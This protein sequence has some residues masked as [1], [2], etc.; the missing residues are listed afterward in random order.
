MTTDGLPTGSE[1]DA[2]ILKILDLV[3]MAVLYAERDEQCDPEN[4]DL[5]GFIPE[6]LA[7]LSG[8]REP[9]DVVSYRCGRHADGG[10]VMVCQVCSAPATHALSA[11]PPGAVDDGDLPSAEDVRGILCTEPDEPAVTITPHNNE[12]Q[13]IVGDFFGPLPPVEPS[14][15]QEMRAAVGSEWA[16]NQ[17]TSTGSEPTGKDVEAREI[18]ERAVANL[19]DSDLDEETDAAQEFL[20]GTP[21][22][23]LWMLTTERL[24]RV[25]EV[26]VSDALF[27]R[28]RPVEPEPV[29]WRWRSSWDDSEPGWHYH[30]DA[31]PPRLIGDY[32]RQAL[33]ASP[34]A[35]AWQPISTAPKDGRWVI[36]HTPEGVQAGYWGPS[37][38][39]SLPMWVQYAHRSESEPVIGEPT[40]WM[41]L[42]VEYALL[43]AWEDNDA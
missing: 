30:E 28:S 26:A 19:G 43:R 29:A 5:A 7:A 22:E 38:F 23:N 2:R 42:P 12:G 24:T 18:A 36:L 1:R 10:N 4:V 31:K 35:P 17:G 3:R 40:H 8:E 37:Y 11:S 20:A 16:P 14:M 9:D 27:D 39:D 21:H 13:P 33:Y 15:T 34:V 41:P 32:E 6:L 25:I